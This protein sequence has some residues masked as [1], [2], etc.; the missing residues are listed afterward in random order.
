MKN[1]HH[2]KL[3]KWV[4]HNSLTVPVHYNPDLGTILFLSRTVIRSTTGA[5]TVNLKLLLIAD[6]VEQSDGMTSDKFE[7]F[8]AARAE[9]AN[10]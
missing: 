8:L 2:Q 7:R 5:L 9:A 6:D 4:V 3:N 10:K 1:Q